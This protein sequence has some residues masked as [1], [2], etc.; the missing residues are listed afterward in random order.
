MEGSGGISN[1]MKATKLAHRNQNRTL[2]W[3]FFKTFTGSDCKML[4]MSLKKNVYIFLSPSVSK[5]L[6]PLLSHTMHVVV[7][8]I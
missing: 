6:D 2:P 1:Q 7:I 3:L 4:I 5:C 8:F